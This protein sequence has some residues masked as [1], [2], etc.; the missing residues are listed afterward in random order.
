MKNVRAARKRDAIMGAKNWK[1]S[2]VCLILLPPACLLMLTFVSCG[3]SFCSK[4][5]LL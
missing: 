4:I 3:D 2:G 5:A 1:S